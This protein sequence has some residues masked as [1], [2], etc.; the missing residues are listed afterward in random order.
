M[1]APRIDPGPTCP[2]LPVLRRWV[3]DEL[4]GEEA[5][6]VEEHVGACAFCQ[7]TLERLGGGLLGRW[8]PGRNVASPDVPEAARA[9]ITPEPAA[10]IPSRPLSSPTPSIPGF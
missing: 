2:G 8:H 1:S 5:A 3:E 6:S 7:R 9:A 10:R 4:P